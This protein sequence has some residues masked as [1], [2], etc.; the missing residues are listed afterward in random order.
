M[1]DKKFK[2]S[3][4]DL[5]AGN[6]NHGERGGVR[7][8][9]FDIVVGTGHIYYIPVRQLVIAEEGKTQL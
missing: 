8:E 9:C 4:G 5:S 3:A 6:V 1:V 2:S 7:D